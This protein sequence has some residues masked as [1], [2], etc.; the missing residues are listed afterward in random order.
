MQTAGYGA[1]NSIAYEADLWN[2]GTVFPDFEAQV[3]ADKLT[4]PLAIY[5]ANQFIQ[6]AVQAKV[7]AYIL[8][9]PAAVTAV[10]RQRAAVPT[11]CEV[12]RDEVLAGL[13]LNGTRSV[14]L[15]ERYY[16]TMPQQQRDETANATSDKTP[17]WADAL[18]HIQVRPT[19]P[20]PSCRIKLGAAW[21]WRTRSKV[22]CQ[23][24]LRQAPCGLGAVVVTN[25][26]DLLIAAHWRGV[27]FVLS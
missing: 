6:Q 19:D 24:G 9:P 1:F 26:R 12:C 16:H 11:F 17:Y 5:V 25:G 2:I 22:W 4:V 18:S 8:T 23:S 13:Q 14:M 21:L 27:E 20:Q 3:E 7:P 15:I 10:F